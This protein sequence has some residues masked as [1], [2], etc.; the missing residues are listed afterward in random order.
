MVVR[1]DGGTRDHWE[2]SSHPEAFRSRNESVLAARL[3]SVSPSARR[4]RSSFLQGL[5]KGKMRR[6]TC[7]A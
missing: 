5:W 1:E 6:F 4:E 2:C 3:T 7:T